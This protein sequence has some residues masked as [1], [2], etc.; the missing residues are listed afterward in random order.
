MVEKICHCCSSFVLHIP[1]R[2]SFHHLQGTLYY[3]QAPE[4][5]LLF[6]FT[7]SSKE[8]YLSLEVFTC[9]IYLEDNLLP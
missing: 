4:V 2:V 8:G 7:K 1:L 3:W 9:R 6:G 5:S